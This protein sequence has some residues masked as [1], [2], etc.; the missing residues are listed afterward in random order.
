MGLR[1]SKGP[2]VV[3]VSPTQRGFDLQSD[4]SIP[5]DARKSVRRMFRSD[6]DLSGFYRYA[7][8]AGRPWIRTGRMGRLLRSQTVFEDLVKLI[9]TTNCSWSFTRIMTDALAKELGE[10]LGDGLHL[11]PN[12]E[13]LASKNETFFR[14]KIRSGYRSTHLPTLAH[15]VLERRIDPEGW[16]DPSRPIEEIRREILSVPGAGPYVAE[17]LLR[18]LGR[19][20]NLGLDSWARGKL[21]EL[22]KMKKIPSDRTIERKYRPHGSY[23]G[24]I[25][26]CDLTRDWFVAGALDDWIRRA[27]RV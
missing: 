3:T 21:K 10:D 24:L 2:I 7:V 14:T 26:W 25:L 5:S 8:K 27:D 13:A 22:W 23:R 15:S 18:L 4:S 20:E 16:D 19:Y 11:F 6:Q 12:A 1:S 9:L 17:N